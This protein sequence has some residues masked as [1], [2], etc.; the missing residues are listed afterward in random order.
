[1]MIV[2][3]MAYLVLRRSSIALLVILVKL[4]L[5]FDRDFVSE[6]LNHLQNIL[7]SDYRIETSGDMIL[8][9]APADVSADGFI[10]VG[11]KVM[12]S[13]GIR[14]HLDKLRRYG[15]KFRIESI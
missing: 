11:R 4:R 14:Q 12:N 10:T 3:L 13:E 2:D 6:Y 7:N 8:S 9:M 5:E 1:M 15:R